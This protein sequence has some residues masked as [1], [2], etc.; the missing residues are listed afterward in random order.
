MI[1]CLGPAQGNGG[2]S[3]SKLVDEKYARVDG[4]SAPL[5]HYLE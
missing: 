4:G 5:Q 3:P 1:R 2:V